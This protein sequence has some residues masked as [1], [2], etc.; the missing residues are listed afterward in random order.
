MEYHL[1]LLVELGAVGDDEHAAVN[2]LEF[3]DPLR[4][5]HH[6]EALPAALGVPDDPAFAAADV[7]PGRPHA[8]VLVVTAD[9]LGA[10]VE[11]HEVVDQFEQALGGTEVAEFGKEGRGRGVVGEGTGFLPPEPVLL[12]G[13]DHAVAQPFGVVA[14][15]DELHGAEE[16]L[17]EVPFLVDQILAD[18]LRHRDGR[19]LEFEDPDGDPVDVE[20][21][22]GP[23]GVLPR[24]RDLFGDREVV[25]G[26]IRPVD[27]VNCDRVF[28]ESGTDLDA[29][30]QETV[31]VAVGFVEGLASAEGGGFVELVER[32]GD[33]D[34]GVALACEEPGEVVRFDVPVV[35]AFVP[36]A[37][38]SVAEL[39]PKMAD[40]AA[41]GLSLKL[42]NGRHRGLLGSRSG[43]RS[44]SLTVSPSTF[45]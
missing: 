13:L 2:S 39:V 25:G 18:P 27:Q 16:R 45:Q 12:A 41:L 4:Q 22:V 43:L 9:L 38:V 40:D 36:V 11:D 3:A 6:R 29:V 26:G 24:D 31:D 21:D 17:D 14:R 15:H 28:A 44:G 5:P 35:V 42:A 19:A 1:D 8:E 32:L 7:L 33:E 34:G 23:L 10:G 37:E 30:A 20:H